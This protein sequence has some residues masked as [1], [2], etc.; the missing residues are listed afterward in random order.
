MG[1]G[2]NSA[3]KEANRQEAERQA[4][5]RNTQS[6]VNSVFDSPQ[7]QADI[8]DFVGATRQF[9][10]QDLNRQKADADRNLTFALA[11]SGLIG[12]STQVDQ[13][14]VLGDDYSRGLLASEQKAQGAGASLE[15]ADQ[16]ARARLISLA[17]SGLD[18]TTAASQA[19]ASMRSNLQAGRSAAEL[20]SLGDSF[21]QINDFVTRSR[22]AQKYRQG[23][24]DSAPGGKRAALYGGASGSGYG[25]YP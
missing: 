7:R 22:D 19:A 23:Y 8:A 25:G 17:T 9:Y 6:A 21:G 12:G 10:Q 1:G 4:T 18:A 13:Q 2:S 24:L 5:I 11:K 14:R 16:D 3:A 15:A 20:G